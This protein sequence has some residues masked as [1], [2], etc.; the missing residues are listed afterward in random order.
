ME[1][2]VYWTQR[3]QQSSS[4]NQICC[5]FRIQVAGIYL[6]LR[7]I[8]MIETSIWNFL[9]LSVLLLN[10]QKKSKLWSEKIFSQLK[11]KSCKRNRLSLI[12][13]LSTRFWGNI[14]A[15]NNLPKKCLRPKTILLYHTTKVSTQSEKSPGNRCRLRMIL[16]CTYGLDFS[17]WL[18]S[19][20]LLEDSEEELAV[21]LC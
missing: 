17:V 21:Y 18:G 4:E 16:K 19:E 9:Y 1:F 20:G 6:I 8:T 14:S 12:E 7:K 15:T 3:K 10:S 2:E 5:L 11:F 13:S